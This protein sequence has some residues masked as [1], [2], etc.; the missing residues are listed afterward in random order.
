[1]A[2]RIV[3][4]TIWNSPSLAAL[5]DFTQD[6]FPRWLLLADDWGCFEADAET[7]KGRAYP[8]RPSVTADTISGLLKTFYEAGFLFAWSEEGRVWG[9]F[10][11][12]GEHNYTTGS[13]GDGK[14]LQARRKTPV[15][16]KDELEAYKL[17]FGKKIE[18]LIPFLVASLDNVLHDDTPRD[19]KRDPDPDPNP[20]SDSPS[21]LRRVSPSGATGRDEAADLFA[22][23]YEQATGTAYVWQSGDFVQLA[24]LR[25]ANRLGARAS[26]ERWAEAVENFFSSAMASWSLAD[27]AVR[28]GTFR[29]SPLDRYGKPVNHSGAKTNGNSAA[30]KEARTKAAIA[31]LAGSTIT[32]R[33]IAGRGSEP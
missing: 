12:W 17:K 32:P 22:A 26:P 30:D 20:N 19:K 25:R 11:A 9:F 6:Q 10:V 31:S 28:F 16:P 13:D 7:I 21:R 3:K 1:M 14:R 27:L 15:P 29:N 33:G 24:K 18:N 2:N 4:D 8:K 5:D 23:R